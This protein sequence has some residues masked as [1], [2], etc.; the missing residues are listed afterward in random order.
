MRRL[1]RVPDSARLR[2]RRWDAIVVGSAIVNQIAEMGP[3]PDLA[4][5]IGKFV[6][7]LVNAIRE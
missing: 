7:K 4:P 1:A 6:A 3:G 5:R 2:A